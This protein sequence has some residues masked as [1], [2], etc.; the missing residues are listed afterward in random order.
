M[1]KEIN[2]YLAE[3]EIANDLKSQGS[4]ANK[5]ISQVGFSLI[6]DM[7]D[8]G[9]DVS[10]GDVADYLKKADDI[11]DE[12]DTVAFGL[13]TDDGEIVKVYVA[14]P[15][16]DGF[17][18]AMA[19]K[20]GTEDDLEDVIAE[21]AQ[22]FD[23]VDVEWPEDAEEDEDL[24]DGD[25]IETQ[26]GADDENEEAEFEIN[27]DNIKQESLENEMSI[28]AAF[29]SRVMEQTGEKSKTTQ[30]DSI[31]WPPELESFAKSLST[32]AQ[33][34]ILYAI[35]L[36][37]LPKEV[38]GSKKAIGVFRRNI[39]DVSKM[40]V[41]NQALRIWLNK[42]TKELSPEENKDE[43]KEAFE[44]AVDIDWSD[45]ALKKAGAFRDTLP[46][47][48]SRLIFD[49]LIGL[50]VPQTML[51]D[52]NK[53][54]VRE[55]IRDLTRQFRKSQRVRVYLNLI[56]KALGIEKE[57]Q[58]DSAAH[59]SKAPIAEAIQ[60]ADYSATVRELLIELGVPADN[61]MYK[62]AN[63][64][65]SFKK[66]K[67]QLNAAVVT[68]KLELFIVL[69][70]KNELKSIN[71]AISQTNY[72]AL[73]NEL[74][75]LLGLPVENMTYKENQVILSINKRRQ[76]INVG[77][78]APKLEKL[79]EFVRKNE[80]KQES[81]SEM[82]K[83]ML[84]INKTDHEDEVVVEAKISTQIKKLLDAGH[85]VKSAAVGRA[86]MTV[87][88]VDGKTVHLSRGKKGYATTFDTGDKVKI[89]KRGEEYVI[90]N[91][92]SE[93]EKIM[94]SKTAASKS[95]I[96]KDKID[97]T[98][99]GAWSFASLG[100]DGG[101]TMKARG[102][103]IVLSVTNAEKAVKAIGDAKPAVIKTE[104]G[105]RIV[106]S[107]RDRGHSYIITGVAGNESGIKFSKDDVERFLDTV[108]GK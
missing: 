8:T 69:L 84:G 26:N 57:D 77:V 15:D 92:T 64:I 29:L 54:K 72:F 2:N 90:V 30:K 5:N 12:V 103:K 79:I 31:V 82:T 35:S 86:G 62:E 38:I 46:R 14:V 58:A 95:D 40:Y 88:G 6:K 94:K 81:I 98:D 52:I 28:G 102:A 97:I 48:L 41:K 68:R 43:V 93:I 34:K 63:V 87:T 107:P 60:E 22:E 10:H 7:I 21:L 105:Q 99:K 61:I 78:I 75:Q 83:M 17:E 4:E 18:K 55:S 66:R 101:I 80:I 85:T 13:E 49:I 36:F 20:L 44:P 23:I 42:L 39:V 33:E 9:K 91:D 24:E 45:P 51:V 65:R 67:L 106:F 37:N 19:S 56:A 11:N 32:P 16:A 25:S 100:S 89:E 96:S 73:V 47:G 27:L 1:I 70:K 76:S 3:K 74:S 108:G 50:G 104:T 59:S 53:G 71:E